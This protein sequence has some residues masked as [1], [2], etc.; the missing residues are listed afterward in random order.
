MLE[1]GTTQPYRLYI[2]RFFSS[3][4]PSVTHICNKLSL[5]EN[6]VAP[7]GVLDLIKCF[8]VQFR[9][10]YTDSLKNSLI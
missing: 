2:V 10:T 6:L 5:N 9:K 3:C 8:H 7:L 4:K 1:F